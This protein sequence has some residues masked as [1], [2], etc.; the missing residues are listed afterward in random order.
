MT[1]EAPDQ[2]IIYESTITCP[3][4]GHRRTERMPDDACVFFYEC[5]GCGRILRP[6]AGD[7]CI[8]C[9]YGTVP[10]PP[11]QRQGGCCSSAPARH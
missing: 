6:R 8:F 11:V 1:Q 5:R 4:C 9:S 2:P 7:C 3:H 10:C